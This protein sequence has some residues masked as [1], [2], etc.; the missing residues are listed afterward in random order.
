[1][2]WN[3]VYR[4]KAVA[5]LHL[6]SVKKIIQS[7]MESGTF[8]QVFLFTGPKG[9]GKTSTARIIGALLNEEKNA[10]NVRTIFFD[11]KKAA[12]P[13]QEPTKDS[14]DLASIFEG[15]SY[16]VQEL[17]AAS[18]RGIDDVRAL[19]ERVQLP[20]VGGTI[21]VYILD[22][23][24]MLTTEAF[25][26][27][28]KLLEEPPTHVVFILATTELQ[29]VPE[30]V[31]SR[32][33]VITF[34]KASVEELGSVLTQIAASEKLSVKPDI[35]EYIA[36]QA[37]GS[38]RDAV[39][40]FE[41]SVQTGRT[42]L[43]EVKLLLGRN[44]TLEIS[45]LITAIVQKEMTRVVELFQELRS[46]HINEPAFHKDILEYL[47]KQLLMSLGVT[48]GAVVLNSEVSR[49]LLTELSAS[50]LSSPSPIPLLRLELKSLDMI[51]RAQKKSQPASSPPT[52][53]SPQVQRSS[54]KTAT[55][56]IKQATPIAESVISATIESPVIQ[57]I[58][59]TVP[60]DELS[61]NGELLFQQWHDFV[62]SVSKENFS[63]AT[64]LKSAHPVAGAIGELT[65]SV[66]Y[67][68][69]Q[70]QLS[71]PKF[72]QLLNNFITTTYGAIKINCVLAEHPPE[73]ELKEPLLN[74]QLQK[75]AVDAL[76]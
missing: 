68:F 8:P 25:N 73:A 65:L 63:L 43:D 51:Q 64:L 35:I 9:T 46:A 75:L 50:E 48:P 70:E 28:L 27:L 22:E 6:H 52:A 15:Q 29:K 59:S 66:Y 54:T 69:H 33:Q 14:P 3:R 39:K 45:S 5:D 44:Y 71:Q 53:V 56:S 10:K 16:L 11:K 12:S 17:D 24:H 18:N 7:L 67:K 57:L 49:F 20:P 31:V 61:G 13:L 2:S 26:A 55:A 72:Q 58:T 30:T 36:T 42:T 1:M 37:N 32:C 60:D 38:F 41:Q 47:H 19:K 40:L 74:N 4:P 62:T 23:V 76:M 21:S 34:S